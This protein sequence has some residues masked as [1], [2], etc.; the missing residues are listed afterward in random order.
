MTKAPMWQSHGWDTRETPGCSSSF[1][2]CTLP[3][4]PDQGS[5]PMPLARG[6]QGPP[7]PGSEGTAVPLC[8]PPPS[9][10]LPADRTP[11]PATGK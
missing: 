9:R 10:A 1:S 2:P 6:S 3:R 8:H 7:G 4:D 11:A 5:E